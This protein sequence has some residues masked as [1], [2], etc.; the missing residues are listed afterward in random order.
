MV[1]CGQLPGRPCHRPVLM[2]AWLLLQLRGSGRMWVAPHAEMD[3]AAVSITAEGQDLA[4]EAVARR[5]LPDGVALP[6][7]MVVGRASLT[8]T[9]KVGQ[10]PTR[11]WCSISL[12]AHCADDMQQY[13]HCPLLALD[14]DRDTCAASQ[15][16]DRFCGPA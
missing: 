1:A 12:H 7:G 15:C 4:A 8:A 3:P 14:L 16:F 9:M 5:Y 10:R 13:L 2:P 6:P 11:I